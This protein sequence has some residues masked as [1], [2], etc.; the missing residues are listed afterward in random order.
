[1]KDQIDHFRRNGY[2]QV[3]FP[4]TLQEHPQTIQL[5]GTKLGKIVFQT[6][7]LFTSLLMGVEI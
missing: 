3:E 7:E 4:K 2:Q 1:M 6:E 5:W